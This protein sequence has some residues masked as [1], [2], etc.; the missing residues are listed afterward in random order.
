M[1]ISGEKR[2]MIRKIKEILQSR[3]RDAFAGYIL[4]E[5]DGYVACLI[6]DTQTQL[7]K[8]STYLQAALTMLGSARDIF[9]SLQL[10]MGTSQYVEGFENLSEC[11][12]QAKVAIMQRFSAKTSIKSDALLTYSTSYDHSSELL[13]SKFVNDFKKMVLSLDGDGIAKSIRELYKKIT[14]SN[15]AS[16][17]CIWQSCQQMVELSLQIIHDHGLPVPEKCFTDGLE[18]MQNTWGL[19]E[20][21]AAFQQTV[22]SAVEQCRK[23][24]EAEN[25]AP[26]RKANQYI[27]DHY[28]QPITLTEVSAYVG[29]NSS[30][31]SSLFK[32]ETGVTFLDYVMEVRIEAAKELLVG[33]EKSIGEIAESIGYNDMKYFYKRFRQSTGISPKEYRRLY[34]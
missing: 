25:T 27:L 13:D 30:Y 24:K 10:L 26:I 14:D 19:C 31:F 8:L 9:S 5:I 3:I 12:R 34:H 28:M 33:T 17:W 2:L 4:G 22:T 16:G 18:K 21:L 1:P 15:V 11:M 23:S 29:L 7:N 20:L 6:N 32:R